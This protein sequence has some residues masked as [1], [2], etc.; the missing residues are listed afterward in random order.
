MINRLSKSLKPH[1]RLYY[2]ALLNYCRDYFNISDDV[3]IQLKFKKPTVENFGSINLSEDSN[4]IKIVNFKDFNI[5]GADI[6]HEFTH[7]KQKLNHEIYV[8][9]VNRRY[10]IFWHGEPFISHSAYLRSNREAYYNFPWEVEAYENM[11]LLPDFHKSPHL[12]NLR[13]SNPTLDY[14]FDNDLF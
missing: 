2:N 6:I 9:K 11:K 14:M 7:I 5:N 3:V 13:G 8:E 4:I 12:R 10:V 1:E